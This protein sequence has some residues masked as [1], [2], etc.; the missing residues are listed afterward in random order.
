VTVM[1]E[2]ARVNGAGPLGRRGSDWGRI[3]LLDKN[4]EFFQ[5][6]DVEAKGFITRTDMRVRRERNTLS[7]SVPV[8]LSVPVPVSGRVCP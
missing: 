3:A 4:K 8:C 6:C 1:E 7:L 5:I 2:E